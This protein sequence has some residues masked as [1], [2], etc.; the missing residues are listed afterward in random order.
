MKGSRRRW[1][2]LLIDSGIANNGAAVVESPVVPVGNGE[3]GSHHGDEGEREK[4]RKRE[5]E[6]RKRSKRVAGARW[7]SSPASWGPRQ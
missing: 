1:R 2:R 4:E 6:K 3:M 7:S 5:E